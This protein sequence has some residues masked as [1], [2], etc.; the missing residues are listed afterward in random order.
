MDNKPKTIQDALK[1]INDGLIA[2][3]ENILDINK[4]KE[5]CNI[6]LT[7]HALTKKGITSKNYKNKTKQYNNF[8]QKA[9]DEYGIEINDICP[10]S[11]PTE[12][13]RKIDDILVDAG[14]T[15]EQ[16]RIFYEDT[17][18]RGRSPKTII[19]KESFWTKF[20]VEI[21]EEQLL[22]WEND[23]DHWNDLSQEEQDKITGITPED[24]EAEFKEEQEIKKYYKARDLKKQQ[25][26]LLKYTPIK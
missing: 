10:F 1:D 5:I 20:D 11:N 17:Q 22:K 21:F 26:K 3:G 13:N 14:L 6:S 23:E 18:L 12:L 24:R 15:P 4:F 9:F 7:L 8:V 25:L 19:Q 16:K 2:Y